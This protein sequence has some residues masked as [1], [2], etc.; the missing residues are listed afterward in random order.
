MRLP[1]Q[2]D[3]GSDIICARSAIV[4]V[5]DERI[6]QANDRANGNIKFCHNADNGMRDHE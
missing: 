4:R 3:Y 1:T 5:D 2:S 6:L